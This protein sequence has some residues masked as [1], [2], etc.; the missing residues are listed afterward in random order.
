[1]QEEDRVRDTASYLARRMRA[2]QRFE[3]EL[4]VVNAYLEGRIAALR[5]L[6][7][8]AWI[9]PES[10]AHLAGLPRALLASAG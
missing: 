3:H 5:S 6:A 1:M 9:A 7:V 8:K 10:A 2:S 4:S